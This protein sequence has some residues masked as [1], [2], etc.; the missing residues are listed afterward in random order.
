M[1]INVKDAIDRVAQLSEAK[2]L[3]MALPIGTTI[4][5]MAVP[6][7]TELLSVK[8]FIDDYAVKPDRRVGTD[9][10]QDLDSLVAWINRH[11]DAGSV[12]FCD[13]TREAPKLLSIIDYH[14]QVPTTDDGKLLDSGDATARFGRFR[15]LYEFPLS[16]HWKAWRKVDGVAM[17]QADFAEFLEERVLDL[18][19]PDIGTDGEGSEVKKLPP[20]V[21]QLLDALGGRCALPQDVI[22]LSKGLEITAT[23]RAVTRV[24]VQTGEGALVFEQ[25]HVGADKQKVSVPKLFLIGI[26]LFDKSSFHYRIPVRIRYRLHG[27]IKWTFTMFGADEVIDAAIREAAE[28]VRDGATTPLFYGTPA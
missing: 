19:A 4:P 24:D 6:D 14:H 1:D 10:V 26:P 12:V 28:H 17:D 18:I 13:T 21:Q 20:R 16:E 11:K 9:K 2:M 22:T 23:S 7:G 15:A 27:G 5:I 3:S 25:D 8:K